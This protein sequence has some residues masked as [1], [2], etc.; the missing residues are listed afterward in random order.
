MAGVPGFEPGQNE[1]ESFVL[2]LHY[3]PFAYQKIA[4]C[5]DNES[6]D[7]LFDLK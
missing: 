3:T 1:P 5:A 7:S 2:P 6:K 4:I